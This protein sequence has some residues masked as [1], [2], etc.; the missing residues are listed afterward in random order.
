VHE[1]PEVRAV[2]LGQR[3][4]E[5]VVVPERRDRGRVLD[6]PLAEVRRRRVARD[7]L[8]QAERDQRDAEA[9][10]DECRRPP[11]EEAEERLGRPLARPSQSEE[12]LP[13]WSRQ[14]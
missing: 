11:R 9:Q 2:L 8:R 3:L 4:V 7:E 1:A 5:P 6:R 10:Q 12:T 13:T 14:R